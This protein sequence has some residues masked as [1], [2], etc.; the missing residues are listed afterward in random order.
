MVHF[1]MFLS[2]NYLLLSIAIERIEIP[3]HD[4]NLINQ[5][6]VVRSISSLDPLWSPNLEV[7]D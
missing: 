7:A 3:L 2:L 4:P 5:K 6:R 1:I